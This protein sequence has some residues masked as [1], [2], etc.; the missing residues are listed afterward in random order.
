MFRVM[1]IAYHV[2]GHTMTTNIIECESK[3]HGDE[4][5]KKACEASLSNFIR[6]NVIKLY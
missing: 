2:S 1:I 5:A 4:I 3:E 6:L